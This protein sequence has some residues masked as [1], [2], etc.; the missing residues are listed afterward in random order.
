[1]LRGSRSGHV[2]TPTGIVYLIT[3][4]NLYYHDLESGSYS[5][6]LTG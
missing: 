3:M 4:V 5:R 2:G 6:H 1:M